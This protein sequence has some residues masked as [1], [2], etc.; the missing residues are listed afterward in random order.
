MAADMG[1]RL[2]GHA[3]L[4]YYMEGETLYPTTHQTRSLQGSDLGAHSRILLNR[5]VL[6][7]EKKIV[8]G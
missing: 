6:P 2:N 4:L 1:V 5:L 8:R 3:E 7:L